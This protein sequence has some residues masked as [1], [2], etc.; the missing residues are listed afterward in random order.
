L[1]MNKSELPQQKSMELGLK[2]HSA[3]FS[4]RYQWEHKD[5]RIH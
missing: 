1:T 3:L 2:S 4:I 5:Q